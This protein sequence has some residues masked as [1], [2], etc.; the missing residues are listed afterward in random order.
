MK[1]K[2][3][4]FDPS[5]SAFGIAKMTVDVDTLVP[6]IEDLELVETERTKDDK[7]KVIKSSSDLER[8]RRV[9]ERMVAA[10]EGRALAISEI[11]FSHAQMYPSA[12][13]NTG[14]VIGVLAS[15]RIPLIQVQPREVKLVALGHHQGAKEEMIHWALTRYPNAPWRTMKRGG[16]LVPTAA[17]EHLADAVAAVEAGLKT[18]QFQQALAMFRGMKAAA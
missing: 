12:I 10:C 6:E 8:A 15:I 4:G 3:V 17:N 1:I 14:V 2:V 13:L 7:L 18:Q 16:K 9:Q 11:P 5:M